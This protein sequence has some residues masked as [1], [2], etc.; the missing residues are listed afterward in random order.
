MHV[1]GLGDW[2]LHVAEPRAR[3][4]SP[5]QGQLDFRRTEAV[6]REAERVAWKVRAPV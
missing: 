1:V 2:G 5:A 3:R 6:R 4:R